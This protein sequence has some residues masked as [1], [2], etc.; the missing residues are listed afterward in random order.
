MRDAAMLRVTIYNDGSV[1]NEAVNVSAGMLDQIEWH[2]NGPAFTITF[3]SSPFANDT[4]QVSAGGTTCSGPIVKKT[5]YATFHYM[6]E[7]QSDPSVRAD[8]DVNVKR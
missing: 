5:P 8:P 1:D 3:E 6:I 2:S 7:S 4:Y